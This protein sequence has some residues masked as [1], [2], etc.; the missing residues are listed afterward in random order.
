MPQRKLNRL[1]NYDY[2][3]DGV[4]FIT[5]CTKNRVNVFG[6]IKNG[7]MV[8]NENGKIVDYCWNDLMNHY[9]N[10]R[11]DEYV[12]MPNHFHAIIW[13]VG[14]GL[15]PFQNTD[16]DS[17]NDIGLKPFQNTDD[18]SKSDIGLKPF[19]NTDDDSQN[20]IGLQTSKYITFINGNMINLNVDIKKRNGLKPFPTETK[21]HG[22]PEIIRGFKTFSSRRINK[23]IDRFQWQ[24]SYYD[25]II[26]NEKEL[27]NVKRYIIKN[28]I[29]WGKDGN[30]RTE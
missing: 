7:E 2:S 19:Q 18:D 21:I 20:D 12:I 25:R 11:L 10:I 4:Y 3:S 30:N 28:P 8:L 5:I 14:N 23:I 6:K 27:N 26:R 13:L 22:L 17:K 9:K 16:D 29:N 24:K 1:S 15:K